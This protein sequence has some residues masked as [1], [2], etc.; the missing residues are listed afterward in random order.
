MTSTEYYPCFTTTNYLHDGSCCAKGK[1]YTSG[2]T[3]TTPH[4]GTF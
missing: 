1:Y 2:D 3:C 4:A